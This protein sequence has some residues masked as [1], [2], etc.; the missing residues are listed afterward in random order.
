MDSFNSVHIDDAGSIDF[1]DHEQL[2]RFREY[3]KQPNYLNELCL[4]SPMEWLNQAPT[5]SKNKASKRFLYSFVVRNNAVA[6]K[7]ELDKDQRVEPFFVI[8]NAVGC[9]GIY[10]PRRSL[11]VLMQAANRQLC[12]LIDQIDAE[13]S[14]KQITPCELS[15]YVG[16]PRPY[17]FYMNSLCAY[18]QV[19]QKGCY[20]DVFIADGAEFFDVGKAYPLTEVRRGSVCELNKELMDE[21]RLVLKA[22][23]PP[24]SISDALADAQKERITALFDSINRKSLTNDTIRI[25]LGLAGQK[26]YWLEQ[27]EGLSEIIKAVLSKYPDV[28]FF[29]DGWTSPLRVDD[30]D[31][32]EINK[33]LSV[34]NSVRERVGVAFDYHLLIGKTGAEK[35]EA[36][37]SCDFFFTSWGSAGLHISRFAEQRGVSHFN[38]VYPEEN[39]VNKIFDRNGWMIP[40][41]FITTERPD[42]KVYNSTFLNY[43]MP[44]NSIVRLFMAKL[45]ERLTSTQ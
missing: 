3:F 42:K 17:H 12:Q 13:F 34:F 22:T 25:W 4:N 23:M 43:S 40:S 20:V 14:L 26:R 10:F 35:I 36:A 32:I 7:F 11:L 37:L 2:D 15:L 24:T 33:D 21:R 18:E 31:T 1:L 16:H 19:Y 6:L 5:I 44:V 38:D 29:I 8:Q 45:S 9:D 30:S 39:R 28:L 27:E 41:E